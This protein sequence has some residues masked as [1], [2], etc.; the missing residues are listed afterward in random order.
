MAYIFASNSGG[1][2]AASVVSEEVYDPV[3]DTP[4]DA[5]FIY[6]LLPSFYRDLMD[7]K[8]VFSVT[9]SGFMQQVAGDLLNLW[10]ID[11]AK[12]L[13]DVPV[14]A[15]R[16]WVQLDLV[17][18]VPFSEEPGLELSGAASQLFTFDINTELLNGVYVSRSRFDATY[19]QLIRFVNERASLYFSVDV[20]V[21]SAEKFSGALFGYFGNGSQLTDG[22]V[23]A[24]LGSE[25]EVDKPRAAII[26]FSPSGM[27]TVA[28]S[29][30]TLSL[31]EGYRLDL[32]Y[33]SG[34][35][36]AV[37]EVYELRHLKVEGTAG[38]T[39]GDESE[40]LTNFFTDESV[41]FEAL[42]V[43]PGDILIAFETEY[44]VLSVDGSTLTTKTIGL[45]V[46]VS[47]IAYEVRGSA[48]VTSCALDIPG[49]AS[50]PSFTAT[51]FGTATLDIRSTTAAI[52]SS[53]ASLKI[54]EL[55]AATTNWRFLDPSF[56][57]DVLTLPRLQNVVTSP[58]ILLTEGTDYFLE[59]STIFFQEPPLEGLWAEYVGYDEAYIADNFGANVGLVAPSSDQYKARVRGLNFAFWQGP[60]V[61][62]IQK[63]VHILIGLPIA[64][65]AGVVE[66]V[67]E[68]FS[69]TLGLITVSGI[70]YLFPVLVGTELQV[71]DEVSTFDPLCLGVEVVDY[72]IDPEWFVN[73]N[74]N[75]LRKFH[76]FAVRINLDAF[77]L[78]TLSLAGEF[79]TRI[80]PTWKDELFIVFKELED[81]II[82][83]DDLLLN[84]VLKLYDQ[85]CELFVAY[86]SVEFGGEEADWK[87]DQGLADWDG[88]SAAMRGTSTLLTGILTITNGSAGG[89][90]AGS[91]FLGEIG[92]PGVVVG[93]NLAVGLYT[94]SA[95][96]H[97]VAGSNTFTDGSGKLANCV[98]GDTIEIT[99][100]GVFEVLLVNS[101][102]EIVL[103]APTVSDNTGVTWENF[104]RLNNWSSLASVAS[105]T[106]LTF[107]T[108]SSLP[109]GT[110][111]FALLNNDYLTVF[112]DQFT[113]SCPDEEF[114]IILTYTG[115]AAP[116]GPVTVPA[117]TGTTAHTFATNGEAYSVVIAEL[118]P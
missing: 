68:A 98:V 82:V 39:E 24:I 55:R 37:L 77:S 84:V 44:E 110:Y 103:D 19:L 38:T 59:D 67:N 91:A 58:D 89:T 100:E 56:E 80:K 85:P 43:V 15:Q 64:E 87:Y 116:F 53:L 57:E 3:F 71:G 32:N 49:D 30:L 31:D 81:D 8:E 35:G 114:E 18:E 21:E 25:T 109:S 41:D 7:D 10:Q 5:D 22:L 115:G 1:I 86:D 36:V 90:G 17:R 9:W 69:G 102:I 72:V 52:F 28:V 50:D 42:E 111:H 11:Y 101:P 113:E 2:F 16:K 34:T 76:T 13:R 40:L 33:T 27:P 23:A 60:T 95:F 51:R 47:S 94:T 46:E 78:D 48:V 83:T 73:L 65:K 14:I 93:K 106:A 54:K 75:E 88:T 92:G 45:P 12:S 62:A 104:G 29:A 70:D 96:G 99:G 107:G 63:G 4:M 20:T 26:H 108:I 79:V 74:I 66:V 118:T 97:T 112:Y 117:A 105:N 6:Q 61:A